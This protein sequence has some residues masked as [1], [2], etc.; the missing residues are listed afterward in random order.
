MGATQAR[1]PTFN[2][3]HAGLKNWAIRKKLFEKPPGF[4]AGMMASRR[5]NMFPRE[6]EKPPA[7]R[8]ALRLSGNLTS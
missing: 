5:Q 4:R 2:Q 3:H 8:R 6:P 1:S 7:R